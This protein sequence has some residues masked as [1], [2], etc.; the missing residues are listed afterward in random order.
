MMMKKKYFTCSH[1]NAHASGQL[2]NCE[3][4]SKKFKLKSSLN[5]YKLIHQETKKKPCLQCDSVFKTNGQLLIHQRIHTQEK[6]FER[7]YRQSVHLKEHQMGHSGERPYPIQSAK[8]S[9]KAKKNHRKCHT[10]ERPYSCSDWGSGL[11][12]A[13]KNTIKKFIL[14]LE[15][16]NVKAVGS[17]SNVI[18]I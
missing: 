9:S 18:A 4:C 5:N 14:K 2:E 12:T 15:L 11:E 17:P 13:L 8:N 16:S 6:P 7:V 10:D 3:I 1:K